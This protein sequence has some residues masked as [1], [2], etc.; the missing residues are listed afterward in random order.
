MEILKRISS[1][2][3][4]PILHWAKESPLHYGED[5][6]TKQVSVCSREL[7]MMGEHPGW[8]EEA[9]KSQDRVILHAG[10]KHMTSFTQTSLCEKHC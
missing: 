3:G 2:T 8:R 6:R 4:E 1:P 7:P 10:L 5:S 9:L